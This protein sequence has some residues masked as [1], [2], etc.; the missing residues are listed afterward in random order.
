MRRGHG[1]VQGSDWRPECRVQSA[2]CAD[3][4]ANAL[5]ETIQV[6]LVGVMTVPRA[7]VP[8]LGGGRAKHRV[9]GPGAGHIPAFVFS[10]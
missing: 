10:A 1:G 3:Q 9:S 7:V 4:S 5:A 2:R 6:N 8:Q